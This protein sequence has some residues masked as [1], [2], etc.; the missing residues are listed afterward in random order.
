MK[1]GLVN[2]KYDKADKNDISYFLFLEGKTINEISAIRGI[3]KSLIENQIIN[4][5]IKY[6]YLIKSKNIYELLGLLINAGKEDKKET[7][8]NFDSSI[9]LEFLTYVKSHIDDLNYK[10]KQ[11]IF[12]MAGELGLKELYGL[13]IKYSKCQD[14]GVRRMIVSAV[15]KIGDTA[16]E[17]ILIGSLKDENP[18]VRLYAVKG[19]LK[20]KSIK[21][22]PY[23]NNL[24]DA[25]EKEYV[26]RATEEYLNNIKG[27]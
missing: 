23:I 17:D 18:Q 16:G 7:I 5:K 2:I 6:R 25:E 13:M 15:G 3:D 19:L 1:Q 21:A 26:I 11:L 4:G 14:V 8:K 10:Y 12:W 9:K 24:K 22:A 27:V 20:L